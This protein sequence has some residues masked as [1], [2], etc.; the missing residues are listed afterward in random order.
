[1]FLLLKRRNAKRLITG[2]SEF[3]IGH[4]F[5]LMNISPYLHHAQ[6]TNREITGKKP[7]VVNGDRGIFPLIP[8]MNVR[9]VMLFI[10]RIKYGN[11]NS[12]KH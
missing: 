4:Q 12:I 3:P 2:N 1:M 7:P 10:V 9:R 6:L 8:Y 11:Q 5:I